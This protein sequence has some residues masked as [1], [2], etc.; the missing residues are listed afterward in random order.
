MSIAKN[1]K[2]QNHGY[3]KE[4][5]REVGEEGNQDVREE[6]RGSWPEGS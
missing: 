6:S 4:E 2:E 3:Y 5:G 1:V